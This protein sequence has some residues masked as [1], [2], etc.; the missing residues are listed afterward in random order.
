VQERL[1]LLPVQLP[2][3]LAEEPVEI[4]VAAVDESPATPRS[5]SRVAA[6]P[7]APL[8]PWMTFLNFFSP[9]PLKNAARSRGRSFTR[10]PTAWR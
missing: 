10:M 7:N 3:L 4:G 6:F 2:R 5:S 1:A 8:A 9:Y